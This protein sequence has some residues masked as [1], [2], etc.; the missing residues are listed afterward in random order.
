M[1]DE[2]RVKRRGRILLIVIAL[3]SIAPL[4][5][6]YGHPVRVYDGSTGE[7]LEDVF[8][9]GRWEAS[10][11]ISMGS[12]RDIC[13]KVLV[14]RTGKSGVFFMPSWSWSARALLLEHYGGFYYGKEPYL[15]KAG[16]YEAPQVS[17]PPGQRLMWRDTRTAAERLSAI[18]HI[19]R[20]SRCLHIDDATE[21]VQLG[22]VHDT[23][24]NEAESL[25]STLSERVVHSNMRW[26]RNYLFYGP[27]VATEINRKMRREESGR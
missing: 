1:T 10:G 22:P 2:Q 14:A 6:Q 9:I 21:I 26:E 5:D 20:R 18:E 27:E 3:L 25:A 8:A 13:Y 16:Y 11:L 12:G 15:Y 17:N 4:Y 24:V 19:Q 7:P 23:L